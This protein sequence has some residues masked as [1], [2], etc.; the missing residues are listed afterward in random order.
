MCWSCPTLGTL[1]VLANDR[2]RSYHVEQ[3]VNLP[4][5][6]FPRCSNP[7]ANLKILSES[8]ITGRQLQ[9]EALNKHK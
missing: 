6:L 5:W 3:V 1:A 2:E 9:M 4:V 7:T 8:K